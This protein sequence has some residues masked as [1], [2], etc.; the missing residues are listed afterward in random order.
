MAKYAAFP[1]RQLLIPLL[2]ALTMVAT[3]VVASPADA[4]KPEWDGIVHA[5]MKTAQPFGWSAAD[6]F[7]TG[8]ESA[9]IKYAYDDSSFNGVLELSG[10]KQAGPYVFTVNSTSSDSMA[11][12]SDCVFWTGFAAG[13]GDTFSGGTNGC[14]SGEAYVD[15]VEFSLTQYDSDDSGTI[16]GDDHFGGSVAIDVPFPDGNYDVKFFIKLDWHVA[17][18]SNI[19]MMNDMNGDP[20]YG[21]VVSPRHF[22]YDPDVIVDG[23]PVGTAVS[24][25]YLVK[26]DGTT[27]DPITGPA[28]IMGTDTDPYGTLTYLAAGPE[29]V[30]KFET[31]DGLEAST[32]YTLV[33][34][35]DPWPGFPAE[36]L[37]TVTTDGDGKAVLSWRSVDL[38]RDLSS[39]KMWFVPTTFVDARDDEMTGW[40]TARFLLEYSGVT[41]DDTDIP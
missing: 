33:Q 19:M 18:F 8:D 23:S 40:S 35:N 31:T 11:A 32:S 21:K 15:V 2:L 27:W 39:A 4:A 28:S 22:G 9:N 1:V 29:F 17:G 10:F 12:I 37:A 25:E 36:D 16:G 41:Y 34:Y 5:P 6:G 3:L 14:W 26:K 24:T 30:Y 38:G 13:Y 7:F 20:R